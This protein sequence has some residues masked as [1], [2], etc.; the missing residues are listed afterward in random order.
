MPN[1]TAMSLD[2]QIPLLEQ[3]NQNQSLRQAKSQMWK[4][5]VYELTDADTEL[6]KQT[7][8]LETDW[9]DVA[10]DNFVAKARDTQRVLKQWTQNISSA[11]PGE[12]LDRIN[13]LVPQALTLAKANQ[14]AFNK[15]MAISGQLALN[16]G[17]S[18]EQLEAPF[19]EPSGKLMDQIAALYEDAG[20]AVT[21]AGSGPNYRGVS[22]NP[23][24]GGGG[25]SPSVSGG[26]G[27]GGGAPTGAVSASPGGGAPTGEVTDPLAG[28]APAAGAD[29]LTGQDAAAQPDPALTSP[30]G[31][32][33]GVGGGGG[34][35]A[36]DLPTGAH[37]VAG[38]GQDPSQAGGL[39]TAPTPS[40][41]NPIGAGGGTGT[42]AGGLPTGGSPIPS[43]NGGLGGTGTGAT[44]SRLGGGTG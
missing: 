31:A 25:P 41:S 27:G 3:E 34:G 14:D 29:G 44:G 11:N 21:K 24:Q 2:E 1:Y 12:K 7:D 39:G 5:A 28:A 13:E 8:K 15:Y 36:V 38:P 32:D 18:K 26:G 17:Y 6:G 23:Q 16:A 22:D 35:G 33:G 40:V 10:G 9:T 4:L 19:R 30:L 43:L 37:A 20:D 42:G